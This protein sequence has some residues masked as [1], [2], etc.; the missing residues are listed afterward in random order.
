MSVA[1]VLRMTTMS[2]SFAADR[3]GSRSSVS[4]T[5]RTLRPAAA[6]NSQVQSAAAGTGSPGAWETMTIDS[7]VTLGAPSRQCGTVQASP[8]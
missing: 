6:W 3:Y 1:P 8:P 5:T 7:P 4:T 2:P